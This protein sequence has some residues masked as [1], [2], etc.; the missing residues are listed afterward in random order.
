MKFTEF[1]ICKKIETCQKM[2]WRIFHDLNPIWNFQIFYDKTV[3]FTPIHRMVKVK[4]IMPKNVFMR[5]MYKLQH[6]NH[7]SLM[8]SSKNLP[9]SRSKIVG[10]KLYNL[11]WWFKS[12]KGKTGSH[13]SPV[14]TFL[15]ENKSVLRSTFSA[16]KKVI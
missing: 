6:R 8:V 11:R 9:K 3:K 15:N 10:F 7:F 16:E 1:Q 2:H 5:R 12:V 13:Y 4:E 14:A